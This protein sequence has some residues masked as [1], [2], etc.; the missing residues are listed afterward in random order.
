MAEALYTLGLF[1]AKAIIILA[2]VLIIFIAFFALLAKAKQASSGARLKITNL[3]EEYRENK[4]TILQETLSKKEYKKLAKAEKAKSKKDEK[5]K[6][7]YFLKFDGDIKASAV[8]SL[9]QE[10]TA[11]LS[12]ATPGD[13]VVVS[14][15]SGG[16]TVNGYGLGAA[17]LMRIRE[18]KIPLTVAI[19]KV[20]ASG[21]YMM[22]CTANKIIAAPFA[23]IGSIGVVI[24]LPNFNKL[25]KEKNIDFELH[26]AGEYKR[27]ITMFGENTDE[28]RKKLDEEIGQI[29]TQFKDLIK[30][31]RP[32]IDLSQAATGEYWL[33]Q[34]ALPLKL[35][36]ELKTS[37]EYL[38]AQADHANI[39]QISFAKKKPFL[40]RLTE[41]AKAVGE[42]LQLMGIG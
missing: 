12:A 37:D 27:T 35:V 26:T 40:A 8:S 21:G 38:Y 22:A 11:V 1:A 31:H 5:K 9:S 13:E 15:E 33:A 42:K 17:Q 3:T 25:L 39:F 14:I 29:H 41:G 28:G 16:G 2:V 4:D 19:D 18:R 24:Q 10:V 36:D 32:Q 7:I 30:Q 20:A 23:I 34:Q 6:N